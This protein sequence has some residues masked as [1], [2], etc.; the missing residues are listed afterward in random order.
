[1]CSPIYSER[2]SPLR[3]GYYPTG[4]NEHSDS[5]SRRRAPCAA[6]TA[7]P[8]Q[9]AQ[10]P[11]EARWGATAELAARRTLPPAWPPIPPS[12]RGWR[13]ALTWQRC[14]PARRVPPRSAGGP[15]PSP[16]LTVV[17]RA[18]RH[19][20]VPSYAHVP[21]ES[22]TLTPAGCAA[23][24]PRASLRCID[25]VHA[26]PPTR[27]ARRAAPAAAASASAS[28]PHRLAASP[29]LL[30]PGCGHL[31]DPDRAP[32]Q[33]PSRGVG[34]CSR[35]RPARTAGPWCMADGAWP[36]VHGRASL[37]ALTWRGWSTGRQRA[38]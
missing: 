28:A 1:M 20:A 31:V 6:A 13:A 26:S 9:G 37:G 4:R 36:M 32:S 16:S 10:T 21:G 7:H 8:S 14:R 17:P 11:V 22:Y 35:R 29:L 12:P 33:A 18:R 15:P 38:A 24:R 23:G 3:H 30:L 34:V 27:C 25:R 5:R 2:S 19:A